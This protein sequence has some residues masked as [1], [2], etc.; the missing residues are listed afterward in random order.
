MHRD[1]SLH[2]AMAKSNTT[3][4]AIHPV[5]MITPR[6][7]TL[8]EGQAISKL[9]TD[10]TGKLGALV[11]DNRQRWLRDQSLSASLVD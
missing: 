1:M 3:A 6:H 8:M 9:R 10:M 4:P 5:S 11:L 2:G 7:P